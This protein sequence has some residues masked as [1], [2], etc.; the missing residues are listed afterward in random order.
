MIAARNA[1]RRGYTLIEVLIAL[2]IF[3]LLIMLAGPAYTEF[4]GNAQ[5]RNASE[6]VL[7]GIRLSQSEA[8]KHNLPAVFTLDPATGYTINID[9]PENPGTP[10]F[11]RVHLFSDGAAQ[12]LL[13]IT[14][15]NTT[16]V[17]FDGLGRLKNPNDDGSSPISAVDVTHASLP[18]PRSLRIVVANTAA[19]VGTVLC[20]PAASQPPTACP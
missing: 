3:A 12:A 13:T 10:L 6:A 7:N 5:I 2:V 15:Q 11:A 14:P 20:D 1:D 4:I 19:A 17:S 8:L 9:D 16:V 18:N